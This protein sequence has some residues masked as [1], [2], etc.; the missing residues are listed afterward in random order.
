MCPIHCGHRISPINCVHRR[1]KKN[2]I[3]LSPMT[4]APARTGKSKK[5]SDKN[6]NGTQNLDIT[7]RFRT[8]LGWSVGVMIANQL[9]WLNR[10]TG[11]QPFH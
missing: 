7:Q 2:E 9:V 3:K 8:D 6:K 1:E 4:K 10:F 5:L 11:S